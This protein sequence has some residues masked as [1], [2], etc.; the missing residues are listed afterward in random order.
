M[1]NNLLIILVIVITNSFSQINHTKPQ[2]KD[3]SNSHTKIY[4]Y[5]ID[6]NHKMGLINKK[7]VIIIKPKYQLILPFSEGLAQVHTGSNV[8]FI[9]S[10]G[11]EVIKLIFDS[12]S[13]FSEGL[14][15]VE[16]NDFWGFIN[17][18]G[19]YIIQ[20]SFEEAEMFSEGLAAIKIKGK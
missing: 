1:T 3:K 10:E 12:A 18:N 14:A 2:N 4:L 19:E 9:N 13:D 6:E 8:G 17:N 7:G 11:K 5:S 16:K 20:P 15:A